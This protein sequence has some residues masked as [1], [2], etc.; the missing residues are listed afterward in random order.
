MF[1][2]VAF[3]GLSVSGSW[4]SDRPAA[5]EHPVIPL[6]LNEMTVPR[7]S[8]IASFAT[9]LMLLVA[10]IWIALAANTFLSQFEDAFAAIDER[11]IQVDG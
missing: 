8:I 7:L 4:I 2:Q 5:E 3:C 1:K 10:G 9:I 6:G 11:E